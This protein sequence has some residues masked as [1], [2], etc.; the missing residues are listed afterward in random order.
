MN[1]VVI[2]Q[3]ALISYVTGFILAILRFTP[4]LVFLCMTAGL[5]ANV[6]VFFS[7]YYDALPMMP[8]HLGILGL[9]LCLALIWICNCIR[10]SSYLQT[11]EAV[12]LQSS[13]LM[14]IAL[15]L[16]FPKDFYLP[17]IRSISIWSHLFFIFG[18]VAK[19]YLIYGGIIVIPIIVQKNSKREEESNL[20]AL[21][22][23]RIIWGYGLLTLA[24]FS[25]EIW[26]YLGWGTPIV[27]QDAAITTI[28]AI[29]F[30]WTCLLHLHYIGSWTTRRRASFMVFGS[31][32]V[33]VLGCHP[34]MGPFRPILFL[35]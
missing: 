25:G 14:I 6:V 13:I 34:D 32:L 8:M 21:A 10:N 12:V 16:L 11:R 1:N 28:I 3:W 20:I 24:M 18:I 7:R 23:K 15:V 19:A 35:G 29:W 9:S 2:L 5:A 33:L 27:W 31:V 17:F 30:Y 26:S 4:K 22:M